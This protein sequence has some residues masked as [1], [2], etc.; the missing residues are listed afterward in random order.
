MTFRVPSTPQD[1][2]LIRR[3][4]V[5]NPESYATSRYRSLRNPIQPRRPDIDAFEAALASDAREISDEDLS[6]LLELEWRSRITAGWL[7]ALDR[8]SQFRDP[9]GEL[10]LASELVYAGIGYCIALARFGQPEDA[11]ILAAYLDHYLPRADCHYNQ[12]AAIGAL[13][14]LDEV[15]GTS[16]ADRFI[17]LWPQSVYAGQDP[18]ECRRHTAELC[19]FADRIMSRHNRP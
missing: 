4:V 15:L 10:L 19:G 13:L 12:D 14:H 8:R 7:I 6:A 5:W 17:E 16:R 3:Y 2:A 11:D 9:L 1:L 18:R